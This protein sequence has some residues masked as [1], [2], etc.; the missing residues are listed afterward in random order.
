MGIA[1][2]ADGTVFVADGIALVR[3]APGGRCSML[4]SGTFE[5][6]TGVALSAGRV[7]VSDPPR[8]Q[9]VILSPAG[10]RVGTLGT[11]GGGAAPLHFPSALATTPDGTVL[12]ADA[13]GLGVARWSADGTFM[14]RVGGGSDT[15]PF[16][17]HP[18]GVAALPGD[19]VVLTDAERD[20]VIVLGPDGQPEFRFGET[21]SAPGQFAHPAGVAVTGALLFVA[22]SLNG[23]VQIFEFVGGLR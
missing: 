17:L 20:E 22:D 7:F 3:V 5:R 21:G 2:G 14:G 1:T 13:S 4:A 23:R 16:P 12:V 18:K 19:R 8:H 6:A 15:A 10:E 11:G 9:V